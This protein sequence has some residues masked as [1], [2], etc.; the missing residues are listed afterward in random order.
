MTSK[1]D[2]QLKRE[3]TD[4]LEKIKV[5][6]SLYVFAQQV[7]QLEPYIPQIQGKNKPAWKKRLIS[8]SIAAAV[9]GV[10]ITGAFV[11]PAG[12]NFLSHV[13]FL[14]FEA[15]EEFNLNFGNLIDSA[16]KEQF[17][18]IGQSDSDQGIR[19][20]ITDAYYVGST[21]ALSYAID[22]DHD[23]PF[24]GIH[25]DPLIDKLYINGKLIRGWGSTQEAKKVDNLH[26]AGVGEIFLPEGINYGE[27]ITL[28]LIY[29]KIG[30][31]HGKW[32]FSMNLTQKE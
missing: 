9:F 26:L 23:Y 7:P 21:V 6:Q 25:D 30:T 1:I 32:K 2:N 8:G 17:T 15:D 19:L 27:E 13:P 10:V 16:H 3:I 11:S 5:P 28:D 24:D 18:P 14:Q 29:D 22:L 4:N 12:A 31:T 20:T